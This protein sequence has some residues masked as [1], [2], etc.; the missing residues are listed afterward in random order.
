MVI[1]VK[2]INI[3]L[4]VKPIYIQYSRPWNTQ[5]E[6]KLWAW[7]VFYGKK[8]GHGSFGRLTRVSVRLNILNKNGTDYMPGRS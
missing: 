6:I 8:Y 4:V 1:R 5:A 3:Y 7:W 2:D